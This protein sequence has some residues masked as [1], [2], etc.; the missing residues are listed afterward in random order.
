MT[1][2]EAMSKHKILVDKTCVLIDTNALGYVVENSQNLDYI[3]Y[4]FLH[5]KALF[6]VAEEHSINAESLY[7]Y[8]DLDK[9]INY[10]FLSK[11]E[12]HEMHVT[13][14]EHHNRKS[15]EHKAL[16]EMVLDWESARF[17]KPDKP[18]NAYDTLV[19]YYPEMI[20]RVLP[21][22][23]VYSLDTP[24]DYNEVVTIQQY[25]ELANSVSISDICNEILS[26]VKHVK[27]IK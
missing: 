11:Q 6:S 15:N 12:A 4:T 21:L 16:L 3:K 18:L 10:L 24:T 7:R 23:R 8:H 26:Y 20:E 17:T 19:R 27:H 9:V 5:R 13:M 2:K 25:N 1:K 14:Q 22:L